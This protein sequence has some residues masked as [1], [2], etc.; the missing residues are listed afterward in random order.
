MSFPDDDDGDELGEYQ[1]KPA[2]GDWEQIKALAESGARPWPRAETRALIQ[3]T[4]EGLGFSETERDE[5]ANSEEGQREF[6]AVAAAR[7]RDGSK[8]LGNAIAA[9]QATQK[10]QLS[11]IAHTDPVLFYRELAENYLAALED[12]SLRG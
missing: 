6:A 9:S 3:R 4:S 11:Q 1:W 2:D 12:E 8:R 10:E 5:L 7:I